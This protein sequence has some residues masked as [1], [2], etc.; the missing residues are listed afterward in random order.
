MIRLSIAFCLIALLPVS[1]QAQT[2]QV[3]LRYHDREQA[4]LVVSITPYREAVTANA[5]PLTMSGSTIG[6]SDQPH[7]YQ[8]HQAANRLSRIDQAQLDSKLAGNAWQSTALDTEFRWLPPQKDKGLISPFVT[9]GISMTTVDMTEGD[10]QESDRARGWRYGGG[11]AYSWSTE[12]DI[13]LGYQAS[14]MPAMTETKIAD[15]EE[16]WQT[17]IVDISVAYRF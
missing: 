5:S 7:A 2:W 15:A 12:L 11:F 1:A 3:P 17:Q 16:D 8:G 13:K 9:G 6:A 14:S 10:R 4:P